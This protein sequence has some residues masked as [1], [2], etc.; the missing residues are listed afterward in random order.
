MDDRLRT[1]VRRVNL[2]DISIEE[3]D[4][5]ASSCL[6]DFV[7][8]LTEDQFVTVKQ[9][10]Y[11]MSDEEA[12]LLHA[13]ICCQRP[14]TG[15]NALGKPGEGGGTQGTGLTECQQALVDQIC[16]DLV[17]TA[18][19]SLLDY[20]KTVYDLSDDNRYKAALQALRVMLIAM[21]LLC[22]DKTRARE[23][24]RGLCTV[25]SDWRENG[26]TGRKA[27]WNIINQLLGPLWRTLTELLAEKLDSCCKEPATPGSIPNWAQDVITGAGTQ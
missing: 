20:L 18:T 26:G 6:L 24:I 15:P 25:W 8:C 5:L 13:S 1:L 17:Q 10:V 7:C 3:I 19:R 9:I 12:R 4:Y 14:A 11:H 2:N 21:Q 16:S 23:T 22:I 27:F